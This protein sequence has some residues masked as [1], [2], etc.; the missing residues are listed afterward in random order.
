MQ[1]IAM[2]QV[3]RFG[4]ASARARTRLVTA[5]ERAANS[6]SPARAAPHPCT[7]FRGG[8]PGQREGTP[9]SSR[10]MC[11]PGARRPGLRGPP[12][13]GKGRRAG[14]E[15]GGDGVGLLHR[16]VLQEPPVITHRDGI[17]PPGRGRAHLPDLRYGQVW[18]AEGHSHP[19]GFVPG[20]LPPEADH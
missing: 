12:G 13:R 14:G 2:Y 11:P 1:E 7:S 16:G 20:H 17:G 3:R 5:A 18:A 8:R 9:A 15:G 19:A 4:Q 10:R 6:W